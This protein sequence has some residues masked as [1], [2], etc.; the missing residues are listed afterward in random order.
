M[1]ILVWGSVFGKGA[2]R[3]WRAGF[4]VLFCIELQ[5]PLQPFPSATLFFLSTSPA[6]PSPSLLLIVPFLPLYD[7][8]LLF[9]I[10]IL[11]CVVCRSEVVWWEYAGP[12][13]SGARAGLETVFLCC[14]LPCYLERGSPTQVEIRHYR[15]A[16]GGGVLSIRWSPPRLGLQAC[17]AMP[18]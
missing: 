1:F 10:F 6:S 3:T 18:D 14:S 7:L 8:E 4:V 12:A 9:I 17:A 11:G 16:A 2:V 15:F 5:A 13:H